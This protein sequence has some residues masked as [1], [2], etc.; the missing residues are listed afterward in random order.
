M[1]FRHPLLDWVLFFFHSLLLGGAALGV[2][3]SLPSFCAVLLY[4]LG[5]CCLLPPPPFLAWCTHSYSMYR[6]AQCVST[7]T[8]QYDN[9]SS[10]EHAW[11]K[12]LTDQD[13]THWCPKKIPSST[14]HVSFLAAP[15]TDHQHKFSLTCLTYLPVVLSLTVKSFGARSIYTLR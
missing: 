3:H 13:C 5:W 14:C 10:R 11:L 15:D 7:Y 2:L 4:P 1:V 9:V 6:C 8:A 12:S